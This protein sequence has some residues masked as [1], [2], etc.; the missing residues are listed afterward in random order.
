MKI[1][2]IEN[3][4]DL[5]KL[6]NEMKIEA[7]QNK[8]QE[9]PIYASTKEEALEQVKDLNPDLEKKCKTLSSVIQFLNKIYSL[10]LTT[11]IYEE[12][13]KWHLSICH[14]DPEKGMKPSLSE[15]IV[16]NFVVSSFF[17][18]YE[19]TGQEG[20]FEEIRHFKSEKK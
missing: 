2:L 7:V 17:E 1:H 9:K 6:A 4:Q 10:V 5:K 18:I 16:A 12:I 13:E 11:D 15:D 8:I 19:E 14:Y 20:S 3:K